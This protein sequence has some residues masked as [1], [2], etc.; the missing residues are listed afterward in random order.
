[1]GS[2]TVVFLC[3]FTTESPSP[4]I[5]FKNTIIQAIEMTH[6]QDN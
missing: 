4:F 1:M 2:L 6:I 3:N 5:S